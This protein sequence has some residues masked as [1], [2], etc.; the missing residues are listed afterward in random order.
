METVFEHLIPLQWF[1]TTYELFFALMVGHV[2]A[3]FALQN[4]FIAAAKNHKTKLGEL[5]WKWVLPAHGLIHAG[6]VYG[7]T[8]SIVLAT[9]ELIC[10]TIIDYLKCD[11]KISF[12]TDQLLHVLCKLLW[13]TLI[14]FNVPFIME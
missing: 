13:I 8:G 14:I 2:L 12:N 10:H 3:D 1:W 4:D 6:F 7:I 11:G 5:Y 9:F